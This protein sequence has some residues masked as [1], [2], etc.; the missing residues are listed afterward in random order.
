MAFFMAPSSQRLEPP[1]YPGRFIPVGQPMRFALAI[2]LKTAHALGLS[3]PPH[4]L[5]QATELIQ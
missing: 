3:I 1:R 4:V 5:L 2:N